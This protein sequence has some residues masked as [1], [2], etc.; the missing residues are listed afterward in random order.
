MGRLLNAVLQPV[1]IYEEKGDIQGIVRGGIHTE[2]I[3]VPAPANLL[4]RDGPSFCEDEAEKGG[5]GD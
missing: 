5:G 1:Q 4:L 3:R 2:A